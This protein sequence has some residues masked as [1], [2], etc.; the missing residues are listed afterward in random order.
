MS[1]ALLA[2]KH[3]MKLSKAQIEDKQ[4]DDLWDET[5]GE[6]KIRRVVAVL[7]I[8]SFSAFVCVRGYLA[9][10]G[11]PID[12]LED[13]SFVSGVLAMLFLGVFMGI[14]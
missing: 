4:L 12:T 9:F 5:S 2:R 11:T 14:R 1:S 10:G 13:V 6:G 7:L 3:K 8:L